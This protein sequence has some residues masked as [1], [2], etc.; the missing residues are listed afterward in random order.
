MVQGPLL[1]EAPGQSLALS[2]LWR[3]LHALAPSLYCFHPELHCHM[4]GFL[5]G[6]QISLSLTLTRTL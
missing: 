4:S 3:R 1:L 2:S 5:L 6:G